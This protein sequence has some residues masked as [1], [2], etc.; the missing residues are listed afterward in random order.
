MYFMEGDQL[1][2]KMRVGLP[3]LLAGSAFLRVPLERFGLKVREGFVLI[4]NDNHHSRQFAEQLRKMFSAVE[5]P[6]LKGNWRTTVNNDTMAIH[7]FRYEEK[8]EIVQ[9]FLCEQ[10]FLTVLIVGGV[11]PEY[12][13][14]QFTCFRIKVTDDCC[15]NIK[16]ISRYYREFKE[17]S[18]E[19]LGLVIR[20]I[21]NVNS[22]VIVNKSAVDSQYLD[23]FR[24]IIAV[25]EVWKIFYRSQVN[26][27]ETQSFR[28]AYYQYCTELIAEIPLFEAGYELQ[29]TVNR[30]VWEFGEYIFFLNIREIDT[31]AEKIIE[32]N[33]AVLVA[34]EAY[35]FPERLLL[36]ICQPILESI[37]SVELKKRLKQE[38]IIICNSSDYTVKKQIMGITGTVM[39]K[40]F[41]KIRREVLCLDGVYPEDT[42][43]FFK[44]KK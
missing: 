12:I 41:I 43:L 39:R 19:N 35:Y 14:T 7:I 21:K 5:I 10:N 34:E 38:N 33:K 37:S 24:Y 3:V 27:E 42:F 18:V 26:E 6:N 36:E 2:S 15:N 13:K 9:D 4:A 32:E 23:L 25:G 30:L 29:Q 31:A 8:E 11:L 1:Q 28:M 44:E 40:R 17:F 22:S 20:E 16:E